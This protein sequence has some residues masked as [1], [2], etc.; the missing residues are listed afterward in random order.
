MH[1]LQ[2]SV[3]SL[4]ILCLLVMAEEKHQTKL[5]EEESGESSTLPPIG[6]D[7]G[8]EQL[9]GSNNIEPSKLTWPEVV[10]LTPEEGERKIKEEMP[11]VSVQVVPANSFVTMDFNQQ[12]VRLYT[13]SSGKIARVPRIG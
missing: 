12:R 2:T 4:L 7:L 5:P 10:G 6:V 1:S 3:F 11:R 8:Y 9:F 13:D